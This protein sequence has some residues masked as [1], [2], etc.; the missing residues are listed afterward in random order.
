VAFVSDFPGRNATH[1]CTHGPEQL[2]PTRKWLSALGE[3]DDSTIAQAVR[4]LKEQ[5]EEGPRLD[6]AFRV[7]QE[8]I[9][10]MSHVR[11][12]PMMRPGYARTDEA[13]RC[14]SPANAVGRFHARLGGIMPRSRRSC[15]PIPC[16]GW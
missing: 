9:S 15:P 16:S 6:R 8:R 13:T 10:T 2:R 5:M 7:L 3:S 4:R 1:I 11:C 14:V 12:D